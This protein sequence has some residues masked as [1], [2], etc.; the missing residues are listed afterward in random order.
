MEFKLEITN[1]LS[2]SA[3]VER[4]EWPSLLNWIQFALGGEVAHTTV[5][6]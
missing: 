6:C 3:A 5:G 4:L 2:D 1:K